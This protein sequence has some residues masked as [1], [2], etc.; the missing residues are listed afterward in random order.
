MNWI[1]VRDSIFAIGKG[2]TIFDDV[3]GRVTAKVRQVARNQSA[4]ADK[5]FP[6]SE[7]ECWKTRCFGLDPQ[8]GDHMGDMVRLPDKPQLKSVCQS[9]SPT[10]SKFQESETL[11][12]QLS[13]P[14][15]INTTFLIISIIS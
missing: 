10:S 12:A 5:R 3:G 11:H 4:N 13:S 7:V 15:R 14:E 8:I 6:I 1:S 9:G 2:R